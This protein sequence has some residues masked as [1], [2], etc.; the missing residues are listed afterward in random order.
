MPPLSSDPI[1]IHGLAGALG[2]EVRGLDLSRP[3]SDGE[4]RTLVDALHRY[5]VLCLRDQK[6]THDSQIAAAKL[7]GEPDVHPIAKGLASHPEVIEVRKPAG[8]QAFFGTAWHTDNSFFERPSS[9]TLLYAVTVPPVGGD[10]L[11]ASMERAWTALSEP[12]QRF[13]EPLRA[14]HSAR[15]AYDPRTTGT[16]KYDGEAAIQYVMSDAIY[17]EVEHP[18]VRVHPE[19]GRRSLYVNPMFTDRIV[20]PIEAR[21]RR[22]AADALRPSLPPGVLLPGALG[23]RHTHDLGQP[24]APALRDRRLRRLRA[25]DVPGD[26]HGRAAAR[27]LQ[28]LTARARETSA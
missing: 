26:D 19:T 27:R 4:R 9:V 14:V 5:G 2:A 20:G 10:T 11:Y 23:A 12:M 18:V 1:E 28:R 21:E 8:E 22:P 6:L 15:E 3:L 7:F 16:A 17:E 25:A 24:L 13:L